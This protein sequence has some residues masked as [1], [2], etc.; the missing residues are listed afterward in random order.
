MGAVGQKCKRCYWEEEKTAY[1]HPSTE[2]QQSIPWNKD[3]VLFVQYSTFGTWERL[4]K[5]E[6]S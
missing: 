6:L 2:P 5:K 3:D 4:K 1:L